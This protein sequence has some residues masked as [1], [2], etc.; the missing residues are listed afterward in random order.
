[1][2]SEIPVA[3]YEVRLHDNGNSTRAFATLDSNKTI[4]TVLEE[5]GAKDKFK[6]MEILLVRNIPGT[7]QKQ[8]LEVDFDPASRHVIVSQDYAIHPGDII[9]IRK[10]N[11]TALDITI[12]KITGA[13][14][15][16]G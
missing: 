9:V 4:Q 14:G 8:K 11:S 7:E 15:L 3:K 5:S 1:M 6:K 2:E 12:D 13:L 16:N 10:D